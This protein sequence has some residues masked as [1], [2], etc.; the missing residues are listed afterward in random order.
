M[1]H[2]NTQW[3]AVYRPTQK[4]QVFPALVGTW[5]PCSL[6]TDCLRYL[7]TP[8]KWENSSSFHSR[9][10]SPNSE[11]NLAW[12]LCSRV[13]KSNQ[14]LYI[15][16]K[17]CKLLHIFNSRQLSHIG[18]LILF[19]WVESGFTSSLRCARWSCQVSFLLP[20]PTFG[21]GINLICLIM[22]I[23]CGVRFSACFFCQFETTVVTLNFRQC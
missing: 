6:C 20:G 14:Y 23:I 3:H 1:N 15:E 5:C 16:C 8:F 22:L 2:R 17:Y 7:L 21:F 13:P 4:G 18:A 10:L 12:L 19:L 9:K 11:R